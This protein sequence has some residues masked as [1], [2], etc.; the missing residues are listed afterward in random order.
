MA[1]TKQQAEFKGFDFIT[2][3][4]NIIAGD[5][6]KLE[7]YDDGSGLTGDFSEVDDYFNDDM[8]NSDREINSILRR[9]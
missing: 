1:T 4:D 6:G 2:S 9:M 3:S 7:I 5:A 8:I